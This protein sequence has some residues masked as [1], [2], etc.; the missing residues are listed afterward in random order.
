M[1]KQVIF[2]LIF[3]FSC[4]S[5]TTK[6]SELRKLTTIDFPVETRI[7]Y[8]YDNLEY[9]LVFKLELNIGDTLFLKKNNFVSIQGDSFIKGTDYNYNSLLI[10]DFVDYFSI[11]DSSLI[12]KCEFLY[13]SNNTYI[14]ANLE[15]NLLWG[16]YEY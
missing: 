11:N 13:T 14:I 2:L 15:N 12:K 5:E 6:L 10:N 1:S 3:L 16:I 7:L 8:Y 4:K 9:Q